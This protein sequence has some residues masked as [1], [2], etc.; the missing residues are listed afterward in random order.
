[1][2]SYDDDQLPFIWTEFAENPEPR[3][4][5]LLL[6]D[7]SSSMRGE[8]IAELNRGLATFQEELLRDPMAAKRVEVAVVTFG[9]VKVIGEFQSAEEFSAPTLRA[10][11]DTP[12]GAVIEHGLQMLTERKQLYRQ[13]GISYYRPWIFLIT[14]GAP[15]DR[16]RPAAQLIREGEEAK[17]FM[18]F[19]VGVQGANME[20]LGKIAVRQP[21]RL[22]GLRFRDLF[23]W[24]S[25]SLSAV[26]R[27]NPGEPV[28][29]EN[30]AAPGG[31]AIVD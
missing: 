8:P 27:S 18:F 25:N 9:P 5:C 14:D 31:W 3:C 10:S 22:G 4:P 17:S 20:T 30:P 26:S 7:V 24:L 11:G 15:T 16:W 13:N 21:L 6:L 23:A 29:L 12:I 2:S 1:M 28:P 19:A